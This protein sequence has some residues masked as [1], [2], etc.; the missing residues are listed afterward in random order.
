MLQTQK[1]TFQYSRQDAIFY[2]DINCSQNESM[3]ILGESGVGKSTLLHMLGGLMKPTA[4]EVLINDQNIYNLSTSELD[5]FRGQHIGIVFQQAHFI[6]ALTVEENLMLC[7]KLA[8]LDKGKARIENVLHRLGIPHKSK[9]KPKNLSKGEQQRLS[10]AR[11]IISEPLILLADEPSSALDDKNCVN[12][13]E[14]LK[15]QVAEDNCALIIV[16]HDH[17]ITDEFENKVFLNSKNI[18]S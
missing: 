11:A 4:G 3:L 2:P 8:G 14:L 13:I 7:R 9:V 10:I 16:T 5:K 18:T 15:E 17:R 1:L 6:E 12:L